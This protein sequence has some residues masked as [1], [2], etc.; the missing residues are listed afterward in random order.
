MG[1]VDMRSLGY[2]HIDRDKIV[3]TFGDV[4][5]FLTEEETC[6]YF[7]KVVEDHNELCNNVNTTL[8]ERNEIYCK[9]TNL[10]TQDDPYP[11][12]DPDDPRRKMTDQEIIEHYVNL[13]ES[14]LTAREKKTL[15]KL[16]LK[17][18]KAFSLRDEIG[19]CPHMEVELELKDTKQSNNAYTKKTRRNT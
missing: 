15:I 2:F 1:S 8:N 3:N 7:C 13:E 16:I 10:A 14:D 11:W 4:C 5:N 18:K 12:L 19:T 9:D 6:E 17:Y